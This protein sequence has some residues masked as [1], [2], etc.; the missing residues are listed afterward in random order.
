[1]LVIIINYQKLRSRVP[2]T[3]SNRSKAPILQCNDPWDR[4]VTSL[5]SIIP[6]DTGTA[7]NMLDV[8]EGKFILNQYIFPNQKIIQRCSSNFGRRC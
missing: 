1:M 2:I 5:D 7:Y 4:Q 6:L 3:G 8:I